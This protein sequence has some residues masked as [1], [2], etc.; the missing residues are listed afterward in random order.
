MANTLFL[1]LD[2]ID[3]S[4]KSKQV[5]LIHNYIFSKNKKEIIA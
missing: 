1:V 4:G 2:G 3:G 5:K